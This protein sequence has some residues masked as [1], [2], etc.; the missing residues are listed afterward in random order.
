MG[1]AREGVVSIVVAST[2]YWESTAA[3]E[4]PRLVT[5]VQLASRYQGYENAVY[6]R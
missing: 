6:R 4:M 5:N 3:P 2:W 1:E